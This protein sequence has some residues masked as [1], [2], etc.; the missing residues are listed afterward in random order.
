R[1]SVIRGRVVTPDGNGLTG[2]RISVATDPQFGFT[3]TRPDGWF[4]IL[5]NGGSMITLQFQRSPFHPIKRTVMVA[6]NEIVV[7]QSPIIM[8]AGNDEAYSVDTSLPNVEK[9][10]KNRN[11]SHCFDHNYAI[12]KPVL[13]ESLRP[14]QQR[15]CTDKSGVIAESQVLQETLAIPGSDL[16]LLYQTSGSSGYLSTINLQLTPTEIPRSLFRVHLR[17]V[18]D[19][20]LFTKVFEAD[21][22][23]KYSYAWNKRNVYRQKVYGLTTARVYVGYEYTDCTRI[24]WT[25]LTTTVRGFDMEISE[26]GSWNLDIHHRYNFH[27]GVFQKGDGSAIYFKKQS[28]VSSTLI[29]DGKPRSLAC[30]SRECDGVAKTNRLLSPLS[31]ASGPDGSVYVGDANLVRKISADGYVYTVFKH[32]DKSSRSG[33]ATT[34]Y[35]YH[36]HLSQFDGHLYISDPERHQILRVHSV[37]R[38]DDPESNY[39][40]FVGSG[41]RCLPRD[42]YRCGD[43]GLAIEARLSF[44]KGMAFGLDGTLYFADGNAIRSVDKK[45]LTINT[46]IGDNHYHRRKQWKPIPCGKTLPVDEVKLRWPTELVIHPIDGSIY[47]LDDQIVFRITPDRRVMVVVGTPSYCKVKQTMNSQAAH[48]Q[49]EA[50]DVGVIVTFAFGTSG[51]LYIGSIAEDGSNRVSVLTNDG[52]I[53]H[54]MGIYKAKNSLFMNDELSAKCEI[55]TCK[56]INGHNCSCS[57][58]SGA[59]SGLNSLTEELKD[60][61]V[62]LSRDTPLSS[63]TSITITSDG[64]V[65]VADEGTFQIISSV[66][67]IPG[68]DDKLQFTI[69]SPETDELYVFNKYGQHILTKNSLTG[70]TMYSFL[71]DVNTSFGKLSAITDSSGSKISFLRDSGNALQSVETATGQKCR[72]TVNAQGFLETFTDPDNFTTRFNYDLAGNGLL[73]SHIDSAGF[74][75]FYEYDPSGRLMAIVK[76]S[77]AR[78]LITFDFNEQG[79]SLWTEE[80]TV[81]KKSSSLKLNVKVFESSAIVYYKGNEFKI[82]ADEDKSLDVLT[83]WREGIRWESSPHKVL[84]PSIPIQAGMFPVLNRQISFSILRSLSSE[85]SLVAQKT[86]KLGTIHWDYNV[87]YAGKAIGDHKDPKSLIAVEKILYINETRFLSLE[88]DRNA[89][90]EILYNNSRR[91]FLV[92]QY[93]NSSRPIQ[94]LPTET[95]LPLNVIYD[96]YGRLSGWQQGS[97][98]SESFLYDR[99]GLLSEIRYP[100]S[101]AIK[102]SYDEV[103]KTKPTKITLRSGKQYIYHYDEKSGIRKITTPRRS[104]HRL[105]LVISLGFYKLVYTPPNYSDKSNYVVYFD[106]QKR[107]IMQIYPDDLGRVLYIYNE[108]DQLAEIVYGGGKVTRVYDTVNRSRKKSDTFSNAYSSNSD[109]KTES[110]LQNESWKEGNNEVMIKY[111][112]SNSLITKMSLKVTATYLPVSNFEFN[113]DYDEFGRKRSI[114]AKIISSSASPSISLPALEFTYNAK[115]GRLEGLGNFRVH[116]HHDYQHHQN[117]SLITDGTATFSKIFDSATHQM[118][119]ISLAIKDKEVYRMD[120]VYNANGALVTTK[121]FMRHLG[122]NKVRVSNFSYDLDGQLTEV[123]GRDQWRFTYDENG[124][125]VI[126]QYMGNRIDILYDLSD[127]VV[128][129]G[130]TPYLSDGRGFVIQRGEERFFYNVFGQ[131]MRSTRQGRYDIRYLYDS[132]GRL[133]VRKDNYGNITQYFYGDIERPHLVTH[134]FN[135]FDS[136]VTTLIYDDTAMPI[137]AQLNHETFY[138]ACDQIGSPLLVFDHRGEVVKEIHRGPY[139]HVL[140]D[141]NPTFYLPVGFKGGIP[142]PVTGIIHF[143]GNYIYDSLVGQWLTPNWA[144]VLMSLKE[145]SFLSL[146]RFSN[147]DPVNTLPTETR[148]SKL[149]LNR[150][151]QHQGIDLTGFDIGGRKLLLNNDQEKLN[152][153]STP[154]YFSGASDYNSFDALYYVPNIISKSVVLPSMP[155]ISAFWCN[156]QKNTQHFSSMSFIQKSK[157]KSEELLENIYSTEISTENVPFGYGIT[158]SRVGDKAII[159]AAPDVD[160]IR[161]DVFT[162]VFNNSYLLDVRLI[163]GSKDNFYFIKEE[164]W[165]KTHDAGNQDMR[166]PMNFAYKNELMTNLNLQPDVRVHVKGAILHIRYGTTLKKE[167]TRVFAHAKKHAVGERWAK[168]RDLTLSN[169]L[170]DSHSSYGQVWTEA[171]K[172]LLLST[173]S[174]PGYRGSYYHGVENYPQLVEDQSNVVFKKQQNKSSKS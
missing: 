152:R 78:T 33:Q 166:Y 137:M 104:E 95:R 84:L 127:R 138:I 7:I 91:P 151:I 111:Q 58:Q 62:L 113:F 140:F 159:Y 30:G 23:I 168:E 40:I 20:N 64:V 153:L 115:T 28:R 61:K 163:L 18:I 134:M 31:L 80:S 37:D 141:S 143:H 114:G 146:Y 66:P 129:F 92:V 147:N 155:L 51:D 74:T 162:K 34:T 88:Y 39:D 4:D 139:G 101:T 12:M 85:R 102:Y 118:R 86:Q 174:V 2:I 89:N 3:L 154:G 160:P 142:E 9:L 14:G 112:Y 145:P 106:D 126:I 76:P 173:G 57:L 167:K 125:L 123:S 94:W 144:Q 149:D 70:Q 50:S 36:I 99:N 73:V 42:V 22:D 29:G 133:A 83:P 38:V 47:F 172:E 81:D 69:A 43:G 44:P 21:P 5:V 59:I 98:V 97:A 55:E 17:I 24:I 124:N 46:I 79:S 52:H 19:G 8:S 132:R 157:V 161:K 136:T 15:G 67:F 32:L 6:W 107:P 122:A 53:Q 41:A 128:N 56:D 130:E 148:S 13:F 16:Q 135:N 110:L 119:Q 90:R 45:S 68:P 121:T 120:L 150:W 65:H 77:G 96:R 87:K 103:G 158:L 10:D 100:D 93:D 169:V 156:L 170:S 71:Y 108:R 171:E 165:Q 48:N 25:T 1:V 49:Q 82:T 131:L 117:E 26:L 164:V 11:V 63:I 54:F 105:S 35:N 116:D 109:Q 75:Y 72:V 60:A 27:Q